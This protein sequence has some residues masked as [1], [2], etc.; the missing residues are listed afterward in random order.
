MN[1][2]SIFDKAMKVADNRIESTMASKF[3]FEMDNG[4]SLELMAIF[5]T[6]LQVKGNDKTRQPVIYEEGL[7]TVLNMKVDKSIKGARVE[8][9]LGLRV[10]YDVF[11][12]DHNTS[13]LQLS[14]SSSDQRG[15]YSGQFIPT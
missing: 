7:L 6:E 3:T 5:D 1:L 9:P 4:E 14:V 12:H 10:V 8:T 13:L 11:Y 2:D 15:A